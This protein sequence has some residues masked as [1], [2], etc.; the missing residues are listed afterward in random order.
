MPA[1]VAS[2]N[3]SLDALRVLGV[4]GVVAI[5]A[6]NGRQSD[7]LAFYFDELGRFAVPMFF[8]LSAYFWK[9]ADLAQPRRLVGRVAARVLPA[10]VV[11]AALNIA[12]AM[13]GD[14]DYR[15]DLSPLGL[16][17]LAWTGSQTADYL[18]FLPALVVGTAIVGFGTRVLGLRTM[19][20]VASLAYLIGCALGLG[21]FGEGRAF[22]WYR[23]GVLF[24]PLLLVAGLIL[25]RNRDKVAALPVGVLAAAVIAFA[26]LHILEGRLL[27]GRTTMGHDYGLM[28]APYALALVALFM[29]L[30]WR[31][32][33]WE[34][35]G[36]ASFGA[37]LVHP[38][39]LRLFGPL[40]GV[41]PLGFAILS[42]ATASLAIASAYRE[43]ATHL[44]SR[45]T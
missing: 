41:L 19:A 31:G 29:R 11:F 37:Y 40:L 3:A 23:N 18:W 43:L 30:E 4:I 10:F 39:L 7:P 44:R 6:S 9:P 35:L 14:P 2:R 33:S 32:G 38:L 22:W 45:T 15:L 34:L 36:R 25:R 12:F 17:L 8:A 21:L 16:F 27:F 24:A 13:L 26:A 42:V 5:H 20:V 28:T 1:P